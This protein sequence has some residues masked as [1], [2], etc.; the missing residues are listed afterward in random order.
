MTVLD[1]W[2]Y[3]TLV[4]RVSRGPRER[5][6]V[7][8][9]PEALER[10]G[11]R[12]PVVSVLL[13]LS[14]VP[15]SPAAATAWLRGLL[16]EG[17]ART[18]LATHVGV[19][20][21]DVVGFLAHY[22]RDTAGAL[23]LVPEGQDPAKPDV[24]APDLSDEQIDGLLVQAEQDGAADQP[25]SIAG[26]ETK[27][28]LTRT[29]TGW[30]TP[31]PGAPSTHI[32]KLSRPTTSAAA[33]LIDTEA[34]SLALARAAG[35]GDV[36]AELVSFG[37]SRT[38]VVRRYDRVPLGGGAVD[39]IHQEDGAQMLGLRT[40]DPERKFQHGRRLPSLA[41][42]AA[43]LRGVGVA[44]EGLLALTTF[45]LAIGNV[46]AHAKNIS[47]LHL[48]D[49]S[50]RLAPAYDVAM[51]LHL[52]NV[53]R[54]FAMDLA[55][56]RDVD[57][58]GVDHLLREARGWMITAPRATAVVVETLTRLARGLE[59]IDRAAHPGVGPDAWGTVGDRVRRL[60]AQAGAES[61]A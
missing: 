27:I 1:A 31:T 29:S 6:V 45:N 19:D 21:D 61:S 10:W 30:S 39:R 9:T 26:L 22:G 49:G 7:E 48:P 53:D 59:E 36:E 11:T 52:R 14:A 25:S 13:P 46:D 32:V 58:I 33:D 54:R 51:H 5:A 34:A 44:P 16:P 23:V 38:I 20:P 50:H 40:D 57:V 42:L 56:E 18:T 43:R 24:V 3:G 12:S 41:A 35:V 28:V 37:R 2:L 15:P 17:R 8:F 47:L 60:L 4:A 55:G